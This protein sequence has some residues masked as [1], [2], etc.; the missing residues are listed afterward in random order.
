MFE[1]TAD[2]RAMLDAPR[3]MPTTAAPPDWSGAK[4]DAWMKAAI[5]SGAIVPPLGGIDRT[6]WGLWILAGIIL[7]G[8]AFMYGAFVR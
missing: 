5:A 8:L 4:W 3:I 6:R 2:E 1:P 7:V